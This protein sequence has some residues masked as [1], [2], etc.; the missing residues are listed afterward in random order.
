MNNIIRRLIDGKIKYLYEEDEKYIKLFSVTSDA[1]E[2]YI[3]IKKSNNYY[4]VEEVHRDD[5][6]NI[7]DSPS[8]EQAMIVASVIAIKMYGEMRKDTNVKRVRETA[9]NGYY[10]EA[11]DII[12]ISFPQIS[13]KIDEENNA[14]LALIKQKTGKYSLKYKGK[15]V[16]N[17]MSASR[18]FAVLYSYCRDIES[19]KKWYLDNIEVIGTKIDFCIVE[20]VFLFGKAVV[21]ED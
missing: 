5:I 10:E 2:N 6:K 14:G 17:E 21:N 4:W 13:F 11:E 19:A 20:S 1:Q 12:R 18:G 9:G 3:R 15:E 7:F 16:L 8:D